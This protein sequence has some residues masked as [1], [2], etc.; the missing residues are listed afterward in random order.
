M[1]VLSLCGKMF[2]SIDAEYWGSVR[3]LSSFH[4]DLK[5]SPARTPGARAMET[6]TWRGGKSPIWFDNFST[7]LQHGITYGIFVVGLC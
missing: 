3:L 4:R 1:D 7:N 2:E 5:V 6:V